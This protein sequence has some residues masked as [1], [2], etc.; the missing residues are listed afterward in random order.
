MSQVKDELVLTENPNKYS[1]LEIFSMLTEAVYNITVDLMTKKGICI[2]KNPERMRREDI[3]LMLRE[4][5]SFSYILKALALH[6]ATV[7]LYLKLLLESVLEILLNRGTAYHSFK[8]IKLDL[9]MYKREISLKMN[10][11]FHVYKLETEL[12]ALASNLNEEEIL[13]LID[14]LK[15]YEIK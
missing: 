3:D 11:S 10:N 4:Q 14:I 5:S 6:N 8:S 2:Y 15:H 13:N 7:P 12:Q 1:T 9:D